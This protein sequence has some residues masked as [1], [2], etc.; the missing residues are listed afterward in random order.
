MKRQRACLLRMAVV[1]TGCLLL[2]GPAPAAWAQQMVISPQGIPYASGGVGDHERAI[3]DALAVHY[4]LRLQFAD[5]GGHFLGDVWVMVH[6]P[7]LLQAMSDGPLFL[8]NLPPGTYQLTVVAS[9][10]PQSRT[11][12]IR[13]GKA[14]ALAFFW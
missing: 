8:A 6:G 5:R 3:M 11:V 12:T 7:V 2:W 10:V 1:L 9:G 13:P 4:N 14:Q